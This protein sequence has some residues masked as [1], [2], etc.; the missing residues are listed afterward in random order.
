[1]IRR[2][3]ITLKIV[4]ILSVRIISIG[5]SKRIGF[6]ELNRFAVDIHPCDLNSEIQSFCKIHLLSCRKIAIRIPDIIRNRVL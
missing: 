4:L 6:C 1:M 2:D 3:A 5:Q